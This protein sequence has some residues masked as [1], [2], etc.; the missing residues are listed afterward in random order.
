M[1]NKKTLKTFGYIW[2]IIFFIWGYSNQ[3]NFL[4]LTISLLFFLSAS[5]CQD[6]YTKIYLFQIWI[7][8]GN[9]MGK[10]NSKII[11][12]ILFF[13]IFMPIGIF[14]RLINKDL[15]S[16]KLDRKAK[17]YFVQRKEQ[18]GSMINQF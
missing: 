14:L 15:L 16:K 7:K 8:F 4:L 9:V 11:I 1:S 5:F 2:S 6:I 17:S 18:A 12:F 10:I 3:M 13:F